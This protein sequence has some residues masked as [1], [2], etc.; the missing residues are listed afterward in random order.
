[1]TVTK[2]YAEF[3]PIIDAIDKVEEASLESFPAS[4]APSWI[5]VES[6]ASI[7][8]NPLVTEGGAFRSRPTVASVSA[9][10]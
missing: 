3:E 2:S 7:S 9:N 8:R 6:N 4:D 1:M 10:Q 5:W